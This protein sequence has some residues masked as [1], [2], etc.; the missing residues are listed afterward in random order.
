MDR[1]IGVVQLVEI[2]AG[3]F[4]GVAPSQGEKH[5]IAPGSPTAPAGPDVFA[6]DQAPVRE[7]PRGDP[8]PH[9]WPPVAFS[10]DIGSRPSM[11]AALLHESSLARQRGSPAG[12]LAYPFG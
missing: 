12:H 9:V 2:R 7:S 6:R 11:D 5:P 10:E 3:T 4:H 8:V 1:G